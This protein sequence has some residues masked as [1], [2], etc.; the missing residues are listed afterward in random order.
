ME[1]I[2]SV[3][4][5]GSKPGL[6]RTRELLAKLGNPEKQLKYV[7]IA[8]TNGKGSTAACC[9]TMLKSAGYKTGLFT[10]PFILRFNE[11]I[12]I[13]GEQITDE[14]LEQLVNQIRPFA[15]AMQ[16]SPTEFEMITALGFLYFAQKKC[17]IVVLEVGMGGELDSTNVIET[18]DVGVIVTIG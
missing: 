17:D 12:Q 1:Y 8:G 4:W 3:K 13:N 6:E 16:D 14:E 2:H 5:H 11:R 15:D 9:A 7:H 18:P 10:S